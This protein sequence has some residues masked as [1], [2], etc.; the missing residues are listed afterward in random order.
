MPRSPCLENSAGFDPRSEGLAKV[1]ICCALVIPKG[2]RLQDS[3][4]SDTGLVN[5]NAQE[6]RGRL[7]VTIS[8]T[9]RLTAIKFFE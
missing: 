4:A 8:K 5:P 3:L 9:N 2:I 1:K 6:E 7:S